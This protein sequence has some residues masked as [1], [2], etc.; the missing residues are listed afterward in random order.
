[1]ID[2]LQEKLNNFKCVSY[3]QRVDIFLQKT[4]FLNRILKYT[5]STL[6]KNIFLPQHGVNGIV[7]L[8]K[9]IYI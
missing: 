5:F 8:I 3:L 2:C 6:C 1:M 4:N 7:Y 9:A